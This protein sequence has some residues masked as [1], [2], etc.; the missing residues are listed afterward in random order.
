MHVVLLTIFSQNIWL[1]KYHLLLFLLTLQS[2]RSRFDYLIG[3][4]AVIKYRQLR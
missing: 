1:K 4:Q 3:N 2:F